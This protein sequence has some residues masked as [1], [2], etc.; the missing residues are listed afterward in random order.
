MNIYTNFWVH[1]DR[2][3]LFSERKLFQKK[4]LQKMIK[5]MFHALYTFFPQDGR[6]TKSS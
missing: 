2:N 6:Y 3:S 5:H 4:I 1:L